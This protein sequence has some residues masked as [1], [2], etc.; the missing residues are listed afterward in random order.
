MLRSTG[1]AEIRPPAAD[2]G[3]TGLLRAAVEYRN[4]GDLCVI[5]C[6]FNL[7]R[8]RDKLRNFSLSH[9]LFRTSGIP[10]IVVECAFGTDP[11][12]LDSSAEAIQLRASAA[13]W[14]KERL[15]NCAFARV[16]DKCTKVAW[17]D[18]DILFQ[19]SDWAVRASEFLDDLAVVQLADRIIRLPRGCA[20]YAGSGEVWESFG[21]VYVK[22]PNAMLLGDFGCHG[23]TGFGWA[24]RRSVLDQVGLYDACIAGGGDHVMAH[25]FCGDW[26]SLCLTHMMAPSGHWYR[27]A[28][29]W[30]TKVY[31]LV[32]A[33]LG[34][35]EGAALHLWH[36]DIASRHHVLRYEALHSA[37][38][39]PN[40]DL[41]ADERGCW[42]WASHK[43]ALHAALEKYM[44][45]RR[46][47][48]EWA[49]KS[50]RL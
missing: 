16:P 42:R 6:L 35:V 21:A 7:G 50:A 43:P 48:T 22:H 19:N 39:D 9:S 30:A 34:V 47:E 10:L 12:I 4:P 2:G 1:P 49:S 33:R 44:V 17:I 23:H 40:Q 38:F 15:I 37:R 46:A 45:R 3:R 25:A 28:V 20:A 11:W 41:E 14:Q 5:I 26:E 36:G 18:A 31:P 32:R 13:L 27:H 29:A 24:A 8:S